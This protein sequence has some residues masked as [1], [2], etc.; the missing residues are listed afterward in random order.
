MTFFRTS[1]SSH[2]RTASF[3]LAV[4]IVLLLGGAGPDT[5]ANTGW[6]PPKYVFFFIGD[7]MGLSQLTAAEMFECSRLDMNPG[8]H[9]LAMSRLPVSGIAETYSSN[10]YITD[11]AAAATA[12]ACGVK[13]RNGFVGVDPHLHPI[14]SVAEMAKSKG[15]RVGIVSSVSID[16]ATPASFYAHRPSRRMYHEIAHDLV[17][18]G[19][20]Y[21]GG[22]GLTDPTGNRLSAPI[23]N[24]LEKALVN[25]YNL[26]RDKARFL[27]LPPSAG[28]TIAF[29][30]NLSNG[31]ALPY[32]IDA[33]PQDISLAEFTRK[34]IELLDNPRGFFLLV[35]GGKIDWACHANDAVTAIHEIIALD[36]ALREALTF[37]SHHPLETLIVISADHETGGLTLGFKGHLRYSFFDILGKQNLSSE[38]FAQTAIAEFRNAHSAGDARFEAFMPLISKHFGL[39]VDGGGPLAVERTERRELETAFATGIKKGADDPGDEDYPS[40][41]GNQPLTVAITHIL[42]RKAGLKWASFSH[43][44]VP[45]ATMAVG[46]GSERFNGFCD[47][48]QIALNLM[49]IMGFEAG[50]SRD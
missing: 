24:V 6:G 5:G 44:G 48:T 10:R 2:G 12:M 22:G 30:R 41:L 23:G 18:S 46:V 19:F 14:P 39:A 26:I 34:G 47:N 37:F 38:A 25:G 3:L 27:A 33:T 15:M 49:A 13:T 28:K 32:A 11:S 42:N 50:N 43:T 21:F 35:E 7:G 8:A 40:N 29:N 9:R 31:N 4:A 20:D 36:F 45:V 16:H 1:Y 17:D